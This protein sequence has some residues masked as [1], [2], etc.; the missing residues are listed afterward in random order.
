MSETVRDY[1]V[2][3]PA[4]LKS[5]R[6]PEKP[7]A[8]I[9]GKTMLERTY[10]RALGAVEENRIYIATD[11]DKIADVCRSF[12][13]KVVMTSEDCL[14]GTD[15]IA[16]FAEK[17]SARTYINVQG[18]EPFMP[19]G[20]IRAIIDAAL[21]KPDDIINGWAWI[22]NEADWRSPNVPKVVIREDGRLMYMSRA[23]IPGNK[24]D[25]FHFSR[26][27]VCVYAFPA[28]ALAEF[29]ARA[30]KTEHEMVEDIEI[31]RFVEMGYEVKMIE[32]D[33]DF[34]SV[35]TPEDLERVRDQL[36]Q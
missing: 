33:P 35:D 20:N 36:V 1:V 26:R 6:L 25:E 30:R 14:T 13:A 28:A 34:I 32:L 12:G 8:N 22:N 5:S 2:V 4:R 21:E 15:R 19:T 17:V 24:A 31:L 10:E 23:P 29:A 9:G 16:E 3:I 18:D 27:Q 11:S 7:L